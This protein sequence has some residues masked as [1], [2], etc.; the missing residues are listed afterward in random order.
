MSMVIKNNGLEHQTKRYYKSEFQDDA[1]LFKLHNELVTVSDVILGKESFQNVDTRLTEPL[2][3][4][5][6]I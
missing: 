1:E 3:F 4:K 2:Y 6:K 5:H